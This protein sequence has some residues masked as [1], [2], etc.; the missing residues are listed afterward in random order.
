MSTVA[1]KKTTDLIVNNVREQMLR[2]KT[3]YRCMGG[4]WDCKR[5]LS[6][7]DYDDAS[8]VTGWRIAR[9]DPD[10]PRR[11]S[12]SEARTVPVCLECHQRRLAA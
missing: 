11:A 9:L 6:F 10:A 5:R 1:W 2:L 12:V 8:R 7:Y 3:Y 4:C